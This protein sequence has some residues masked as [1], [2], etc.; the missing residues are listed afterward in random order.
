MRSASKLKVIV[1][2]IR[3]KQWAKNGLIFVPL[4]MAHRFHHLDLLLVAL[5]AF[6]SFSFMASS[7]YLLNDLS[8]I[9][10]DRLHPTKRLRPFAA[11]DLSPKIGYFL[12]ALFFFTSILIAFFISYQF[13]SLLILYFVITTLYT[14]LLKKVMVLDV[15][16][17]GLLYSFR[18]F[19]GGM[20]TNTFLSDWLLAFSSFLFLGLAILKR[21][22][23]VREM[24][25]EKQFAIAGRGYNTDDEIMLMT[26]GQISSQ[27]ALIVFTLF[28]KS[29]DVLRLYHKPFI[30][31][32]IVP[33]LFY[34]VFR[35][36]ILAKRG[37]VNSDPVVFTL[38]EKQNYFLGV[39][40][41]GIIVAA[42][43]L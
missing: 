17:L 28:I 25:N 32:G 24:K 39:L 33:I 22:I 30:L 42:K 26:M 10:S 4:I 15:I 21:Y 40:I 31:W 35:L 6:A 9:E 19:A 23:E 37:K 11:G 2:A 41:V 16:I 3:V 20:A 29:S 13:L 43:F 5:F 34:W 27:M 7:V 12:I 18:I 36:W 38:Q 1:K 8:D 14:F